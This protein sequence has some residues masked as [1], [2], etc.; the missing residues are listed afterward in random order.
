MVKE[1]VWCLLEWGTSGQPR[2]D[3]IWMGE[4]EPRNERMTWNDKLIG[5]LLLIV[6]MADP[7]RFTLK[8]KPVTY[9]GVFVEL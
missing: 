9:T 3:H 6:T 2:Q 7:E 1:Y 8:G 4:G 5:K